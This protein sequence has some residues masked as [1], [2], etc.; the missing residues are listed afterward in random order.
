[1]VGRRRPVGA[2]DADPDVPAVLVQP[3]AAG[4]TVSDRLRVEST[5]GDVVDVAVAAEVVWAP[6]LHTVTVDHTGKC[7]SVRSGTEI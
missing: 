2:D 4:R 1:V 7:L 3:A 6:G 5:D